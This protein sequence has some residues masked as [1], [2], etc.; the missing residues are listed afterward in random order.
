MTRRSPERGGRDQSQDRSRMDLDER[1]TAK[2]RHRDI[3]VLLLISTAIAV[4]QLI[5]HPI[6]T[7]LDSSVHM[8]WMS[9]LSNLWTT[10]L[11]R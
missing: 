8:N 10:A 6:M 2:Q 11:F 7:T 9:L 5:I 3:V 1:R 4:S